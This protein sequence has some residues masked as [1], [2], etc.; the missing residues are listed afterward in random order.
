[1]EG[2]VQGA[3]GGWRGL[4][5]GLQVLDWRGGLGAGQ[6]G[7]HLLQL[8]LPLPPPPFAGAAPPGYFL[9]GCLAGSRRSVTGF[10]L[11]SGA[12]PG[13]VSTTVTRARFARSIRSACSF[14]ARSSTLTACSGSF[15]F[16]ARVTEATSTL[17]TTVVVR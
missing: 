12:P 16:S 1:G 15:G 3:Q 5:R 9:S 13:R 17:G 8:A 14:V 11:V 7:P 2:V 4:Y 10:L 6:V